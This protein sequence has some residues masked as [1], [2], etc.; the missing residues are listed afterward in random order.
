M[1]G[2]EAAMAGAVTPVATESLTVPAHWQAP[3]PQPPEALAGVEV[4]AFMK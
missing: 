2:T 3:L 1:V 4:G